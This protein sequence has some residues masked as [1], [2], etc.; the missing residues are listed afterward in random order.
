MWTLAKPGGADVCFTRSGEHVTISPDPAIF[1]GG[2]MTHARSDVRR[3]ADELVGSVDRQDFRTL[4][5]L[6]PA[7][8]GTGSPQRFLLKPLLAELVGATA[9]LIRADSRPAEDELFTVGLIDEAN[10]EIE[11]DE[12]KPPLR[13]MLRAV[14]A[15]LN[16]DHE[17]TA[18]QIDFAVT[19]P[20]PLGRLDALVHLLSWVHDLKTA[21]G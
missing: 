3:L 5:R 11:I 16:E 20:Q 13:A 12:V 8:A 10:T 4:S 18:C 7:L 14:L 19:D 9:A 17:G 1:S 21:V 6:L 2:T 15:E